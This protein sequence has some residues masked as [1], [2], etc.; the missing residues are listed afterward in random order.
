MYSP[1]NVRGN[2]ARQ[3]R[4]RSRLPYPIVNQEPASV[5]Q[6]RRGECLGLGGILPARSARR[7]AWRRCVGV[8]GPVSPASVIFSRA[9]STS[10]PTNI[11]EIVACAASA[12]R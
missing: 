7:C 1:P 3:A 10:S 11:F 5:L 9:L 6:K 2:A 4:L 12:M 8:I